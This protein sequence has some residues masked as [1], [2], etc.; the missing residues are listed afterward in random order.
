MKYFVEFVVSSL[1]QYAEEVDVQETQTD[2]TLAYHIHL[3]P[4][5]IG[6]VI[7]KKGRTIGAIRNLVNAANTREGKRILVEVVDEAGF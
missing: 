7:G 6:R 4:A 3:N 1:V 5:D 2:T